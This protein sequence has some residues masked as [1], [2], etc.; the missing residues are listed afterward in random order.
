M[1]KYVLSLGAY[2]TWQYIGFIAKRK[3]K[4]KIKENILFL[5]LQVWHVLMQNKAFFMKLTTEIV[6][7]IPPDKCRLKCLTGAKEKFVPHFHI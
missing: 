3:K 7:Q 4:G 2:W 5:I 6:D 1:P